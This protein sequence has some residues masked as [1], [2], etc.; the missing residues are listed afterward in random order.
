VSPVTASTKHWT[1]RRSFIATLGFGGVSLYGLWAAYGAAPGPLALLGLGSRESAAATGGG[2]GKHGAGAAGPTAEEFRRLTEQ[3]IERYRLPDGSVHP[4]V[5]TA[6][7]GASGMSASAPTD[8]HAGHGATG[9]D[10][11]GEGAMDH[12]DMDHGATGGAASDHA[13]MGGGAMDHGTAGHA[14]M[15][16]SAKS[17]SEAAPGK[18][19]VGRKMAGHDAAPAA[20]HAGHDAVGQAMKMEGGAPAPGAQEASHGGA[21]HVDADR[22]LDVYLAAGMWYYMP[23]ALRLDAG[24]RYRFRMMALDLSHGASIQFGR[25]A[26][27]TRLHPGRVTETEMTFPKPGRYLVNC[28]VYCGPAHDTMQATI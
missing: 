6:S 11:A 4:R 8:A 3:F 27:M 28:T 5:L 13:A 7:A 22:P 16:Q 10:A 25:G 2:H 19:S 15:G 17:V 24:R 23:S 26:R 14:A 20:A 12:G 21:G 1:T 9:H 18:A